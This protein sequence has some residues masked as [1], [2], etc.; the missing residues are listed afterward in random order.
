ML[1]ISL[2]LGA[3]CSNGNEAMPDTSEASIVTSSTYTTTPIPPPS[4]TVIAVPSAT[5]ETS[6]SDTYTTEVTS[7]TPI[8]P[9]ARTRQLLLANAPV[10]FIVI[11]GDGYEATSLNEGARRDI[12]KLKSLDPFF[13][14]AVQLQMAAITQVRYIPGGMAETLLTEPLQLE[15]GCVDNTNSEQIMRIHA[16]AEPY[17]S[18]KL[19]NVIL[20]EDDMCDPLVAGFA[21]PD[22]TPILGMIAAPELAHITMHEFGHSAAIGHAGNIKCYD[23]VR[24]NACGD[25]SPTTDKDSVMGYRTGQRQVAEEDFTMPE[26]YTLGMLHPE[27]VAII[28]GPGDY[29]LNR[30]EDSARDSLKLL[31]IPTEAQPVV[32]SWEQDGQA[33]YD[34]ECLE[35]NTY[36]ENDNALYTGTKI[37]DGLEKDYVCRKRNERY[38]DHTLQI[39]QAYIDGQLQGFRVIARLPRTFNDFDS[40][41]YTSGEVIPNTVVYENSK[42]RVSYLGMNN[43]NQALIRVEASS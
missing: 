34:V 7:D 30:N 6:A 35:G 22:E 20:V 1:G 29:A 2:G 37:V 10:H 3:A 41:A 23:P 9:G 4:E 12:E 25:P 13:M 39:R 18:P 27:E 28:S 38:Q 19:L 24:I 15:N 21:S 16:A 5:S 32:L 36:T 42:L 43:Q 8:T 31:V 14:E 33:S 17:K 26:L 11:P 40:N